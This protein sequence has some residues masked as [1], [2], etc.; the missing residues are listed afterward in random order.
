VIKRNEALG[1]LRGLISRHRIVAVLGARQVGK[2]TLARQIGRTWDGHVTFFDLEDPEELRLLDE[3]MLALRGLR[4]LVVLDEIQRRPELFP[5]LRVLCDQPRAPRFLILGSASP[6]L[7]R[8]SS[9]S[10]A[11]RIHYYELGGLDTSDVGISQMKKLWLRGGFPRSYLARTNR[12]SAEWRRGF[13][14]T[15]LERDLP[16]LGIRTPG[17]TIGRFWAMLA[18]YHGQIWNAA[19]F[20]R[21]FGVSNPTVARYLDLLAGTFVVRPLPPWHED[22]KKRQ[23]RSPKIYF[24]DTGLLH[25]QLNITDAADLERHPKLGASWEGL[26]LHEVLKHLGARHDEAFFWATHSGAELDLLVVRGRIRRAFEFKRTETPQVTKSMRVAMSDL[27]LTRLAVIHAGRHTFDMG[28]GI[29]AVS[30][31]DLAT[32]VRPLR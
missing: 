29:R 18:H 8:Q 26:L 20:A 9:E 21:S 13:T 31:Q 5:V 30:W 11:G 32:E 24:R 16:Q 3:P 6:D 23:V 1:A 15:F 25:T 17:R 14:R 27:G 19:E 7:L 22:L 12:A 10:L 28:K 2:T 4:G